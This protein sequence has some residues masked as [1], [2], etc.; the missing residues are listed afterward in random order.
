[1]KSIVLFLRLPFSFSSELI[2]SSCRLFADSTAESLA[3]ME[4]HLNHQQQQQ[5][6]VALQVA[7]A[8]AHQQQQHAQRPIVSPVF[9]LN[10]VNVRPKRNFASHLSFFFLVFPRCTNFVVR[11]PHSFYFFVLPSHRLMKSF[12]A[13]DSLRSIEKLLRL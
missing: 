8:A 10:I 7:S 12:P 2:F 13:H 3:L 11:T 4:Q 9:S 1:M 6:A 5:L